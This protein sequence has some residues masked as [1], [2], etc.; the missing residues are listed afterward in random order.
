MLKHR[1]SSSL[2]RW[3]ALETTNNPYVN[4]TMSVN[5]AWRAVG[6]DS[7]R[8][9]A[10]TTSEHPC[11]VTSMLPFEAI[12]S[13]GQSTSRKLL[14]KRPQ[15]ARTRELIGYRRPAQSLTFI[16]SGYRMERSSGTT[17]RSTVSVPNLG[18]NM[19]SDTFD[20]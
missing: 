17:D 5:C 16:L 19:N 3:R 15:V 18:T 12:S 2:E 7:S 13:S 11:I 20:L 4:F 9:S 6:V 1:M 10:R 8:G 14:L